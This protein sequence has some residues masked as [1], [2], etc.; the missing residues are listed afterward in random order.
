MIY[1][2][3]GSLEIA[4]LSMR[5]YLMEKH[6]NPAQISVQTG[7]MTWP[8][9]PKVF[10]GFISDSIPICG[11]HRKPYLILC[12]AL[13]AACLGVVTTGVELDMFKGLFIVLWFCIAVADVVADALVVEKSEGKSQC[14]ATNLQ[15]FAWGA[16]ALGGIISSFGGGAMI[17]YMGPQ[18]MF[19]VL[20]VFPALILISGLL[21]RERVNPDQIES[22]GCQSLCATMKLTIYQL[23]CTL[24]QKSVLY[25]TL[26]IF[27]LSSTPTSGQGVEYFFVHELGFSATFL[28]FMGGVSS[29]G[30]IIAVIL[31]QRY[32]R[33]VALRKLMFWS[34][35]AAFLVGSTQL[36]LVTRANLALGI[37][38]EAFAISDTFILRFTGVFQFLSVLVLCSRIC[39]P[40]IE[41]TL[42][43]ALMGLLNA[44][45]SIGEFWAA[46]LTEYF[47]VTCVEDKGGD[48]QCNFENLW[49]LVLIA[50]C[51]TLLPLFFLF[52]I[53]SQQ[54]M[55]ALTQEHEASLTAMRERDASIPEGSRI[56]I[57]T[58]ESSPVHDTSI[59][60]VTPGDGG[61][62]KAGDVLLGV[63]PSG[64]ASLAPGRSRSP[65]A[66]S[67]SRSAVEDLLGPS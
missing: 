32:L 38:D 37:P 34:S 35:I 47:D 30:F 39:P 66:I 10:Y 62:P 2:V 63:N 44:A 16:R 45:G 6:E 46:L 13:G 19:A 51:T 14:I 36:L 48:A 31:Y 26:F 41:G 56:L 67:V 4:A 8:W 11:Y 18:Q 22:T 25:P 23:C 43:A 1:F 15:C 42:F 5:L 59:Q 3:Q 40:G 60:L 61:S 53:P 57:S 52:L 64:T 50:Q 17:D 49:I 27:F 9:V 33:N 24:K 21:F 7:L 65:R 28:G 12:G 54:E 55:N 20:A 58:V 29:I